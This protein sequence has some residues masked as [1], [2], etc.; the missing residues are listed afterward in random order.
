[1]LK[2]KDIYNLDETGMAAELLCLCPDQFYEQML[3]VW[4]PISATEERCLY[5]VPDNLVPQ[6]TYGSG[7]GLLIITDNS[8]SVSIPEGVSNCMCCPTEQ[9]Q[10][11]YHKLAESFER[12]TYFRRGISMLTDIL[13]KNKGL[14]EMVNAL[15]NWLHR[16]AAVVDNTLQFLA[17]SSETEIDALVP[18]ADRNRAGVTLARLQQ[19]QKD[20]IFE[21]AAATAEP[22]RYVVGTFTTFMIPLFVNGV[23]VASLGFPGVL[24]SETDLIPIEYV[25]D[26]P[27]LAHLFSIELAKADL[28]LLNKATYFPYIFSL[29]LDKDFVDMDYIRERLRVF[30][31]DL[32]PNIYLFCVSTETSNSATDLSTVADTLRRIFTNSIYL[33]RGQ[34]ILLLVS[35]SDDSLISDFELEMWNSYLRGN[36]LYAGYT[37]PFTTFDHF[38]EQHLKE[39][40]LALETGQKRKPTQHLYRFTD[41]QTDALLTSISDDKDLSLFC[42]P[43][44]MRLMEYDKNRG[45]SLVAT[46]REYVRNPR[47]PQ[48]VCRTLFIHKNTLYQRVDKIRELMNCDLGDAEVIMQ[49]Q[50]TFHILENQGQL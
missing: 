45:T 8:D 24:G 41:F 19:L 50:L 11:V 12:Q 26:F 29:L 30:K 3:Y 6:L 7:I 32:K 31:Y 14:N 1:M 33:V 47:Q 23:K 37:G 28:F 20:G 18:E 4:S 35:R 9:A 16:P 44:L 43:P 10:S 34:E 17:R 22:S 5:I 38:R 36:H 27:L 21:Q 2:W 15:S 46:L 40:R 42:Y 25:Y 49:I 39:A 13:Q 48:E